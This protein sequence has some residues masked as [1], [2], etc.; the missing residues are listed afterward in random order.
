M[1]ERI[2]KTTI[3]LRRGTLSAFTTNN[4][5][6]YF[7]EPS[8]VIGVNKIKVGDG[9]RLWNDLPYL[10]GGGSVNYFYYLDDLPEVGEEE[11]LYY[12]AETNELYV[13]N[14]T[15][16]KFDEVYKEEFE[17]LAE[18]ISQIPTTID[19]LGQNEYVI[20]DCGDSVTNI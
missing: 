9:V 1:K 2:V 17:K 13:W 18:Q 20:F 6:L 16:S 10:Y 15:T 19:D 4:P 8:Y 7:G 3:Q 14:S 5:L 11:T 12:V